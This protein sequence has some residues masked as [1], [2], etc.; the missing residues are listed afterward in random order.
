MTAAFKTERISSLIKLSDALCISR[1]FCQQLTIH[2]PS[3]TA[4]DRFLQQGLSIRIEDLSVDVQS[5]LEN[6]VDNVEKSPKSSNGINLGSVSL[7]ADP[8]GSI[9]S[10]YQLSNIISERIEVFAKSIRVRLIVKGQEC[11]KLH[12]Q[13]FHAR[14]SN[15]LWQDLKDLTSCLDRS[16]DRLLKTRFKFISFTC[17]VFIMDSMQ[18]N[19]FQAGSQSTNT[20]LCPLNHHPISIRHTVFEN[21]ASKQQSWNVL[22][23]VYDIILDSITCELK[24]NELIGMYTAFHV[25]LPW[26]QDLR[27]K[28]HHESDTEAAKALNNDSDNVKDTEDSGF[29]IATKSE[30]DLESNLSTFRHQI[31]IR[32]SLSLNLSFQDDTLGA[33]NLK[34]TID[35]A[36]MN[37]ILFLDGSCEIQLTFSEMTIDYEGSERVFTCKPDCDVLSF[38]QTRRNWVIQCSIQQVK[39]SIQKKFARVLNKLYHAFQ[40]KEQAASIVCGICGC[41]IPLETI[42]I[43]ICTPPDSSEKS[44]KHRIGSTVFHQLHLK[45]ALHEIEIQLDNFIFSSIYQL[46]CQDHESQRETTRRFCINAS[47]CTI[48]TELKEFF[49]EAL[50]VPILPLAFQMLECVIS[51][52]NCQARSKDLHL[53]NDSVLACIPENVFADIRHFVFQSQDLKK[54]LETYFEIDNLN[55]RASFSS[56]QNVCIHC[57]SQFAL[58]VA[59]ER[60]RIQL[61]PEGYQFL[62]QE[63]F[64]TSWSRFWAVFGKDGTSIIGMVMFMLVLRIRVLEYTL[65]ISGDRN[66]S[67]DARIKSQF[68][69]VEMV[70]DN[71]QGHMA[72]QWNTQMRSLL[73]TPSCKSISKRNVTLAFISARL[74]KRKSRQHTAA[75]IIQN[76]WRWRKMH[77]SATL[78]EQHFQRNGSEHPMTETHKQANRSDMRPSRVAVEL[79]DNTASRIED[80]AASLNSKNVVEELK[81]FGNRASVLKEEMTGM[82]KHGK[83]SAAKM[84]GTLSP[85]SATTTL[86]QFVSR[87][88]SANGDISLRSGSG[89]LKSSDQRLASMPVHNA[90]SDLNDIEK[91]TIVDSF[92]SELTPSDTVPSEENSERKQQLSNEE[93]I[94]SL[95]LP[96]ILRISVQIGGKRLAIPISPNK[97]IHELC[98]EIVRRYN[99]IYTRR[100]AILHVS[101]QDA[102]GCTFSPSDLVGVIYSI[103][104]SAEKQVWFAHEHNDA[105][106]SYSQ[107]GSL[108]VT[109]DDIERSRHQ[110]A[111]DFIFKSSLPI[112]LVLAL[113]ANDT[114]EHLRV[115][116]IRHTHSNGSSM[117]EWPD[118]VMNA[119]F[120]SPPHNVLQVSVEWM[121]ET[122]LLNDLDALMLCIEVLGRHSENKFVG[123]ILRSRLKVDSVLE[124]IG[125][126]SNCD[127]DANV[128]L[129]LTDLASFIQDD[130]GVN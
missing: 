67:R 51:G 14:T 110:G 104:S 5:K 69:Q 114:D 20:W 121:G 99:E 120:L 21:R 127:T 74:S 33:Q 13:E 7:E 129:T 56:G 11:F 6:V 84:L 117:D 123:T 46:M 30:D 47:G 105:V 10:W 49:G 103:M 124:S 95:N 68:R 17:S 12:L 44:V 109:T 102:R 73:Q 130:F 106:K 118:L 108:P 78:K 63:R 19:T 88:S 15:S 54:G 119:S 89:I 36:V 57:R 38:R 122:F 111:K 116:M 126:H 16:P 55:L 112:P 35:R 18:S 43:H 62:I 100:E 79:F 52:C 64:K 3:W 101:I 8:L 9:A 90:D 48:N 60:L 50:F 96:S 24:L 34:W 77:L 92:P 59:I 4:A 91:E 81:R 39:C 23:D 32:G 27:L 97:S 70:A 82:A 125:Y 107:V 28:T 94:A 29:K 83:Q 53:Q 58:N 41:K 72:I 45:L 128:T 31:T 65:L 66:A 86:Q 26:F 93:S 85:R 80:F 115:G 22:S 1:A 25:L 37:F 42:D 2:V 61:D 40:E 71:Q 98:E 113:L 75:K 87:H 76:M